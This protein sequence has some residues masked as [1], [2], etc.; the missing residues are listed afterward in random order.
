M[1]CNVIATQMP[2]TASLRTVVMLMFLVLYRLASRLTYIIC[3]FSI[4]LCVIKL[5]PPIDRKASDE[6]S[7]ANSSD[8]D[9]TESLSGAYPFSSSYS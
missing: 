9:F 6:F 1:T 2:Q 7:Q 8:E 4:Q 5:Y 3:E